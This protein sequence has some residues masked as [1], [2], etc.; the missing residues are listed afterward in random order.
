MQFIQAKVFDNKLGVRDNRPYAIDRVNFIDNGIV[1]F[2][3]DMR[4]GGMVLV[5]YKDLEWFRSE[6]RVVDT[7]KDLEEYK[8]L[9]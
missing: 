9:V 5:T 6:F 3:N 7:L 8:K 1:L 2:L 4:D